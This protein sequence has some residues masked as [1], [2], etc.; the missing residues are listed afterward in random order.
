[1]GQI[2]FEVIVVVYSK[3]DMPQMHKKRLYLDS[4]MSIVTVYALKDSDTDA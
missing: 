4:S 1:M 2:F 3:P